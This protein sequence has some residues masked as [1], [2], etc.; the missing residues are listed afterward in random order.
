MLI[1]KT[2]PVGIDIT[3]AKAQKALHDELIALWGIDNKEYLCYERCYRN[4]KDNGYIAEVYVGEKEYK[5]VYWNDTVTAISF[6]GIG[7]TENIKIGE[8]AKVHLVFFVDLKKIKPSILH[9]ADQEVRQDVLSIVGNNLHGLHLESMD[10]YLENCLK[11][12]KSSLRDERLKFVDMHPVHCFR[13]NFSLNYNVLK[14][15]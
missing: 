6:F 11:E 10:L 5:E 12:Y 13:L 2:N 14:I 8:N 4:K 15:C 1:S 7:E 3:I 9:R